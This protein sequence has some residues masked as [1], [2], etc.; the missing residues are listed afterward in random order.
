MSTTMTRRS[1]LFAAAGALGA[2]ATASVAQGAAGAQKT[3]PL[4]TEE[5]LAIR[6]KLGETEDMGKGADGH[7]INYPIVGGDFAGHGLKGQVIPGGAD[8]SVERNDGST[9]VDA[10]YRLKTDDGQVII[11]HN[12]GIWRPRDEAR[13]K[14]EAGQ[15]LAPED[16]YCITT[17]SFKTQPGKHDWLSRY[18]F[19]GTIEDIA[20]YGVLIRCFRV[21]QLV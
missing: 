3:S 7:R 4:T 2:V 20:D 17:P 8:L 12:I 10:L 16:Y 19:V 5:V 6:V 11:I 15:P 21:D 14:L 1:A 18:V 13:A 9:I